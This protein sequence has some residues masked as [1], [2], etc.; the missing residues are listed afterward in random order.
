MGGKRTAIKI[1]SGA[2]LEPVFQHP[3]AT[4]GSNPLCSTRKS[5]RTA[6]GSLRPQSLD[7]LVR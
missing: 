1:H 2:A 5:A 3:S 6:L 7:Y 4:R